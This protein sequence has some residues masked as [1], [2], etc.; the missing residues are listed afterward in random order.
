MNIRRICIHEIRD[1]TVNFLNKFCSV[2]RTQVE[3]KPEYQNS[4]FFFEFDQA[5]WGE[6]LKTFYFRDFLLAK[7]NWHRVIRM[8]DIYYSPRSKVYHLPIYDYADYLA[9]FELFVENGEIKSDYRNATFAFEIDLYS[10]GQTKVDEQRLFYFFLIANK[11][12]GVA[13]FFATIN[14]NQSFDDFD[15]SPD[16]FRLNTF[17]FMQCIN[18]TSNFIRIRQ[19][20]DK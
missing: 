19:G 18:Q 3:I 2:K 15:Q 5:Q 16:F 6:E 11:Y 9:F 17:M 1:W 4:Y 20:W 12:R 13:K 14:I 10:D 7:A 8:A